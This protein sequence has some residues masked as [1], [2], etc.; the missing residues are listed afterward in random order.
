MMVVR[1]QRRATLGLVSDTRSSTPGTPVLVYDGD[2]GFCTTCV[3]FI[4]RHVRSRAGLVAW[5]DADLDALGLSAAQARA[6]VQWVGRDHQS[7]SGHAAIASLLVDAGGL[8]SLVGRLMLT[9][10]VSLAAA[11]VY[12]LVSHNR[13]RLPGGTPAC[14]LPPEE[15]PDR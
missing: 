5:Q 9:P 13:G 3:R 8:W 12:R 6:A 2:C 14:A 11:L 1:N 4:R 10:P 7:R 15:R